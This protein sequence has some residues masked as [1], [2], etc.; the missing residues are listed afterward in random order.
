MKQL[1]AVVLCITS[2]VSVLACDV[3]GG[4]GAMSGIGFLPNSDFHFVG[5]SYRAR[6]FS[7]EHP[8]LFASEATVT[9]TNSFQTAELFG[10][11]AAADR[12]Q[13]MA[14][15]PFHS[16]NIKDTEGIYKTN[17]IGDVSLLANYLVI[18]KSNQRWFVGA[19]MKLPT[20]SFKTETDGQIIPNLQS[21]TGSYD[22]LFTSNYTY[23]KNNVG[24]NVEANY[25]LTTANDLNY[26][27]GNQLDATLTCFYKWKKGGAMY[28]PQ[29]SVNYANTARD[30]TNTSYN[31]EADYTGG[32]LLSLPVGLDVYKGNFGLRMSYR[33]PV[34]SDLAE[35]Y[36]LP[37]INAQA[38]LLYIINKK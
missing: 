16:R 34:A 25:T 1:L 33:F 27:F 5:L 24:I 13:L 7:T 22:A 14:F 4:G 3:C 18:K 10:R 2:S 20:G 32:S 23:L 36:V 12:I 30:I 35:G 38:Q 15:L 21:G 11:Y 8:K 17:G 19:G 29:L 9:G 6:T 26:E 31:T 28:V 37:K